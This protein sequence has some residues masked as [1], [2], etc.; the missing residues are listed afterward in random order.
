MFGA[1]LNCGIPLPNLLVLT[2]LFCLHELNQKTGRYMTRML[3]DQVGNSI[4][5]KLAHSA[6]ETVQCSCTNYKLY[7]IHLDAPYRVCTVVKVVSN[8]EKI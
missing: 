2:V 4:A 7:S 6:A 1:T 8:K 3:E 5:S